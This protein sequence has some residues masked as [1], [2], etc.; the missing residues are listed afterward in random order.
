MDFALPKPHQLFRKMVQEFA[1]QEVAPRARQMDRQGWPDMALV[2][3][4][5]ENGLLGVPFPQGYGGAG[6]G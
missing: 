4:L 6:L 3:K 5:G 2:R 1:A